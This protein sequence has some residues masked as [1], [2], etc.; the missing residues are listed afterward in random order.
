MNI[1]IYIVDLNERQQQI[2]HGVL[3][4]PRDNA[5]V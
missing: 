4:S 2:I 5:C 1:A 3:C